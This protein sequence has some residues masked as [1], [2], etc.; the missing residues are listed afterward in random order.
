MFR[1]DVW[2]IVMAA[3]C[4]AA[5]FTFIIYKLVRTRRLK[6]LTG[7]EE[8][9]GQT[10]SVRAPLEHEGLVFVNGEIWS[11]VSEEGS[12]QAN[13]TVVISRVDGLKLFVARIK[14]EGT[15]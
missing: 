12:V 2:I 11:A 8:L 1:V 10:A 4:I 3:I 5:F 9:V 14:K 7:H 15:K 6:I 13:E